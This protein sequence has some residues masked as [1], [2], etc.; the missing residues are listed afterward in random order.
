MSADIASFF[1]RSQ[2]AGADTSSL[3][4]TTNDPLGAKFVV[5]ACNATG[6]GAAEGSPAKKPKAE[7]T[8]GQRPVITE[9]TEQR[10]SC[11]CLLL[12]PLFCT[13]RD[14]ARSR[15]SLVLLLQPFKA[16]AVMKQKWGEQGG[17]I[18]CTPLTCSCCCNLGLLLCVRVACALRARGVRVGFAMRVC[19]ISGRRR[20]VRGA[21]RSLQRR[22]R[23][24]LQGQPRRRPGALPEP[25]V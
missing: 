15:A 8:G 2:H 5:T 10:S 1:S 11:Y 16:L 20:G 22:R 24:P 4:L 14:A 23:G 7:V 6:G 9:C 12:L 19:A 21:R 18:D 17:A 25:R 13:C 3:L